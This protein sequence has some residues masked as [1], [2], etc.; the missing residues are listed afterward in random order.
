MHADDR[1]LRDLARRL[2]RDSASA[3]DAAQA[4]WESVLRSPPRDGGLTRG[5][6]ATALRN[7][8]AKLRRGDSRRQQREQRSAASEV[9]EL[10]DVVEKMEFRREL[11]AAVLALDAPYRDVILLRYHADLTPTEIAHRLAL[12]I[13]TVKT[14]LRRAREQLA[15]RLGKDDPRGFV[16]ALVATAEPTLRGAITTSLIGGLVMA[17]KS[18]LIAIACAAVLVIGG[19]ALFDHEPSA[20]FIATQTPKPDNESGTGDAPLLIDSAVAPELHVREIAAAKSPSAPSEKPATEETVD[21]IEGFVFD[22]TGRP[23]GNVALAYRSDYGFESRASDDRA[24]PAGDGGDESAIIERQL[25]SELDGRFRLGIPPGFGG[26]VRSGDPGLATIYMGMVPRGTRSAAPVVVLAPGVRVAGSVVDRDGKP[27]ANASL[28]ISFLESSE[29]AIPMPLENAARDYFEFKTGADGAFVCDRPI[30]TGDAARIVVTAPGFLALETN[31]PPHDD[32]AFRIVLER[33]SP[34]AKDRVRGQ[35]I[36]TFGAPVA[37]AFVVLGATSTT[38]D[39]RGLFDLDSTKAS[40]SKLLR[41]IALGALPAE[42]AWPLDPPS[43]FVTLRLGPPP[44]TITGTVRRADGSPVAEAILDLANGTV[45]GFGPQNGAILL[46][47][48]LAGERLRDK[49]TDD[50]GAFELRG[51][52][53]RAYVLRILEPKTG[54]NFKTEP[55]VAGSKN[56]SIVLPE[57]LLIPSLAGRVID[58]SGKGVAGVRV[59]VSVQSQERSYLYS[60]YTSSEGPHVSSLSDARG[61][62]ELKNVPR[63]SVMLVVS[64]DDIVTNGLEL[65]EEP[66]EDLVIV[67]DRRRYLRVE[68]GPADPATRVQVV[69]AEG[70]VLDIRVEESNSVSISDM[71]GLNGGK[72][73]VVMISELARAIVL[74]EGDRELRRVPFEFHDDEIVVIR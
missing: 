28:R 20:D 56:V 14:R 66:S 71:I 51:L 41:A 64:G 67:V 65:K 1:W 29:V 15:Q 58:R 35:V 68:L 74:F 53:Q 45:F 61:H 44:L 24:K 55:I 63:S 4:T 10:V 6:L 54:E 17:M 43:D 73:G 26:S 21:A 49:R 40:S 52:S 37:G 72:S 9:A 47:E 48:E 39:E 3:E 42:I 46:D 5:F 2:L 23:L 25:Q 27:V 30:P 18:K 13:A 11:L 69:D 50:N 70:K 60:Q 62:F 36:D 7:V 8:I 33:P 19:Y 12:P 34:R 38:T 22:M 32:S 31:V 16:A 57:G 59:S